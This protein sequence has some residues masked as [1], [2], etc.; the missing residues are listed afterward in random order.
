MKLP[1]RFEPIV[2][3]AVPVF[4]DLGGMAPGDRAPGDVRNDNAASLDDRP[5]ADF[6]PPEHDHAIAD[7]HVIADSDVPKHVGIVI[8]DRVTGI[9][10]VVLR[11]E[12]T[13]DAAVEIVA[14]DDPTAAGNHQ[15]VEVSVSSQH[16]LP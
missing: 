6:N 4:E 3:I 11:N 10:V 16:R 15:S 9:E 2:V 12:A 8:R 1:G 13:F 7:P 14:D 5:L